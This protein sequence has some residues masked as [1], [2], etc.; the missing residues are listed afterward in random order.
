MS[1]RPDESAPLV[2][3]GA[4]VAGLSAALRSAAL[5][6]RV[7]LF[8]ARPRS[9]GQLHE[10][11]L[12]VE[13]VPGHLRVT[14][15]ALSET[16]RAQVEASGVEVR[17]GCRVELD[18]RSLLVRTSDGGAIV[19]SA[20]VIATG[21]RRR[22][23]G[24][25]GERELAGRGVHHNVGPD[26][27]AYAGRRVVIVGGGDDALE[28]AALIAPHAAEL[29]L[30]H[31]SDRFSARASIREPVLLDARITRRTST[32]VDAIEGA[33]RV[34]SVRLRDATGAFT[35]SADDVFVCIG[36]TPV[37]EGFGVATDDRGYVRVDRLQRT[38]R[39]GVF[40]AGDVCC[41]EAPTIATA[42]GHGAIA[43]KA[44]V[45]G[46]ARAPVSA[47]SPDRLSLRGL[48]L[49]ARIGVYPR[50]RRRLQ[51]LTFDITFEIDASA[52]SPSDSLQRTIDYA[53][54]A[55]DVAALLGEQH[56]NLIETVADVLAARLLERFGSRAITVRVTKP[57]VPQRQSAA[58][59]EVE[60]RRA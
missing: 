21:V 37:S 40:A 10:I 19:P 32:A 14:G 45:A 17:T 42:M 38:S 12:P 49:P 20:V 11:P 4:G 39:E 43:A 33:D 57:G 36:P 9:G 2:V 34:E 30:V 31:R 29:T 48:S 41:P 3:I 13:N 52:A 7:L 23:L 59:I 50:E 55:H 16:L 6:L 22:L 26:P 54:V 1:A 28:H 8:E 53:A 46:L 25:R 15:E 18:A 60:R 44:V 5:G 27:S 47:P 24:V 51:T 35:L 56:F 58:S